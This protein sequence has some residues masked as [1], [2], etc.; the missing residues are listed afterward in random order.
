MTEYDHSDNAA[1][2]DALWRVIRAMLI[3]AIIGLL[4]FGAWWAADRTLH[5]IEAYQG[6]AL[7]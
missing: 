5:G 6:E 4:C 1:E 2:L 3:G 7:G